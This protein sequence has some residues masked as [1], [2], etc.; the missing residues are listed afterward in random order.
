MRTSLSALC[1]LVG[2]VF[3]SSDS[4]VSQLDKL[5]LDMHSILDKAGIYFGGTFRSQFFSSELDENSGDNAV[6]WGNNRT[7]TNEFTSV[8]FDIKARPN[9]SLSGRL[10][11]R[12][13]QNWQNFFSDV[14]NPIFTRWIS[15]DGN[16]NDMFRFNVGDYRQH[17]SPLTLWSPD[18]AIDYEPEIF[19]EKRHEA[20]KEVF[21]GNND[22]H[23]QGINFTMDAE[24]IP[25]CN[26]FHF[27]ATVARLRSAG[28]NY[29]NGSA[30]ADNFENAPMDRYLAGL[31]L[32]MLFLKGLGIGG[33][34]VSVFDFKETANKSIYQADLTA[35]SGLITAFRLQP[36]S[37]MFMEGETFNFGLDFETA[38]SDNRD[39]AW[40]A[41]VR[42]T[43]DTT[44]YDTTVLTRKIKGTAMN[45][46]VKG[47]VQLGDAAKIKFSVGFMSNDSSY[48][49]EMAQSPT[50]L[51]QRIMNVENDENSGML[52]STF[53]A[54]YNTV[55]KFAPNNSNQWTKAPR[56]K[57]SYITA[58]LSPEEIDGMETDGMSFFVNGDG[59]IQTVLPYGPATP[60]RVGPKGRLNVALF[61]NGIDAGVDFAMLNEVK[62]LG[63]FEKA[64]FTRVGGG[65]RIDIATWAKALN[66]CKV[67]AGY[68]MENLKR[69][70]L[71]SNNS[72]LNAGLYYNFWQRFSFLA[73]YQ[74]II[75]DNTGTTGKVKITQSQM[76]AGLEYKVSETGKVIGRFGKVAEKNDAVLK[77]NDFSVTQS[78][79][80]LTVD[81]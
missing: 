23:L 42:G 26:E 48:L 63:A 74:Q 61:D 12:M 8:D 5:Q 46:D 47:K 2:A 39:T 56:R 13:H 25:I 6:D 49:N 11:F 67:S 10:I 75:N 65:L 40:F 55:F 78:E 44:Q 37:L 15:I 1:F 71:T 30:V 73:G 34:V 66:T 53:D 20:E 52:Y 16:V 80:F 17:Y 72:F 32:D 27:N 24:I 77:A 3:A 41:I 36:N 22:R 38:L 28:A 59:A 50:F 69:G 35:R 54:L 21:I 81:F 43:V 45:I 60:N 58:I 31:N 76:A 4:E 19:A 33:S 9:E 51:G 14:A 29:T 68:S 79:L 57:I 18:I 70:P 62:P 7:E 64:S